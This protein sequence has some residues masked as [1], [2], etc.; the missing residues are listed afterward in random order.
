MAGRAGRRGKDPTGSS[1]LNLDRAFGKPPTLE[2]FITLLENKGTPLE[3]KLKL[4]YALTLNVMKSDDIEITDLLKTSFF[5]SE[6]EKE[7]L[8][9]TLKGQKL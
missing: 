1:I 8:E 3:S 5:E 6:S 4:S 2:D 7:R 9:A